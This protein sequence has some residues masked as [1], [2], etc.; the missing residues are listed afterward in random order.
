MPKTHLFKIFSILAILAFV[1]SSIQPPVAQAQSG[2]GIRRETIAPMA[3]SASSV[4]TEDAL[5]LPPAL[6]GNPS[7]H[8]TLAWHWPGSTVRSLDCG[9]PDAS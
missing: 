8:R 2:D 3:G 7:V 1:F 9:M 6:W 4:L 5:C